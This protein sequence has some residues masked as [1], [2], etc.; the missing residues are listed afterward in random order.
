MGLV[1]PESVNDLKRIDSALNHRG[2]RTV[3]AADAERRETAD[4]LEP[5]IRERTAF[6]ARRLIV[7]VP[8]AYRR[9]DLAVSYRNG[10]RLAWQGGRHCCL[11]WFR[12]SYPE[13]TAAFE[14]GYADGEAA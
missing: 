3:N 2:S 7:D 5:D 13:T 12:K 11:D 10:F 9:H 1:A 6:E 14:A 4:V 8:P